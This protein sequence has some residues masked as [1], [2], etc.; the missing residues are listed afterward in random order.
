MDPTICE[1]RVSSRAFRTNVPRSQTLYDGTDAMIY[2]DVSVCP[3]TSYTA[4]FYGLQVGQG[5]CYIQLCESRNTYLKC[6]AQFQLPK[7]GAVAKATLTW[8]SY[9]TATAAR[10]EAYVECLG[11]TPGHVNTVLIDDITFG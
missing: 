7:K 10:I 3:S 1:L 9:K 5:K 11:T 4:S 2:Q 6:G 8:T